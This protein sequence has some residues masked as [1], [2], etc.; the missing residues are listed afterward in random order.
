MAYW[1][2]EGLLATSPR[3][4]YQPGWE[5]NV[6]RE[7]VEIWVEEKR[8]F[9]VASI[10]CLI[11]RD[12]LPLYERSLPNGLLHFYREVGFEVAH[13]PT[14][15]G[16]TEPYTP[17]QYELAWEYFTRLP[18]PVL[19]HCSAGYDRTGRVVNHILQRLEQ[20][21]DRFGLNG[22]NGHSLRR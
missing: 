3:P 22:F 20:H 8:Q 9:G 18:K 19:V 12:Q 11:S 17:D 5:S 14:N 21:G 4:G 15:D 6:P 7:H 2:I 13:L 16:L 1:V 10:L